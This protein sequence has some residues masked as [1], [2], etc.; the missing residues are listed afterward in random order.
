[1]DISKQ[2]SHHPSDVDN[3]VLKQ[4]KFR[5]NEFKEL[6]HLGMFTIELE[7]KLR[8]DSLQNPSSFSVSCKHSINQGEE[9]VIE[10]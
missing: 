5:L 10:L 6:G 4:N 7:L 3:Q 2:C 8:C 1:M 9:S